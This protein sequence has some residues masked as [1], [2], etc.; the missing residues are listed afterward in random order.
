MDPRIIADVFTDPNTNMVLEVGTGFFNLI[1]VA[2]KTPAG[3]VYIAVGA[4]MSYYE[5]IWPQEQRL[6]DEEWRE[7]LSEGK[8]EQPDWMRT[9][10]AG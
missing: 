3:K 1:A 2:Y 10:Q 6:T 8:L 7:I 4:V 5:F 9:F